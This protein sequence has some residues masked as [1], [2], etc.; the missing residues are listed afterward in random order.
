MSQLN[1]LQKKGT[2]KIPNSQQEEGNN[3]NGMEWNE[4]KWKS[5]RWFKK[6]MKPRTD[7]QMDK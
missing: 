3:K 6:I 7:L 5:E 4:M 1:N 2:T